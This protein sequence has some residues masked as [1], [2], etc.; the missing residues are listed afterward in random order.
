[1]KI[2]GKL[3]KGKLAKGK[4]AKGKLARIKLAV[5]LDC[6]LPTCEFA[7]LL[8]PVVRVKIS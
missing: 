8:F 2:R 7:Y 6:L 4:L 1:M 5:G 3:A